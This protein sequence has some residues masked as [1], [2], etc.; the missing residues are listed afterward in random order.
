MEHGAVYVLVE[1]P[2]L[3]G[4]DALSFAQS[5]GAQAALIERYPRPG[6][7]EYDASVTLW[8]LYSAQP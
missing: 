3:I 2:G 5:I 7:A 1:S 4:V 8:R 6:E